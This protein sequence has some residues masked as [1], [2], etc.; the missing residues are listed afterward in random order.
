[1]VW[2]KGELPWSPR[3]QGMCLV[4]LV[5]ASRHVVRFALFTFIARRPGV[6]IYVG[7]RAQRHHEELL[8]LDLRIPPTAPPPVGMGYRGVRMRWSLEG[9]A[10]H[11]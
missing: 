3:A 9:C 8:S 7:L 4:T 2:A 1:M 6:V 11:I 10:L 5:V